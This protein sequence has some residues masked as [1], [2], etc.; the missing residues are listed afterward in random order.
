MSELADNN[1]SF[2][3]KSNNKNFRRKRDE[4]QD[5]E[6]TAEQ[7]EKIENIR[8][9]QKLKRK[10]N[11]GIDA[12]ELLNGVREEKPK[13]VK[14]EKKSGGGLTDAKSIKNDLDLGNTFSVETNRRDEDA[15]MMKF[16][17]QE[18][19]KKKGVEANDGVQIHVHKTAEDAV[20]DVLPQHLIMTKKKESE[21]MLS[22]QMLSGI[23]EVDLGLEEK[24][25][26][27]EDTEDAK[28]TLLRRNRT[29]DRSA[30]TLAPTN[31]A[32]NFHQHNRFNVREDQPSLATVPKKPKIVVPAVTLVEEPVVNVGDE[33]KQRTFRNYAQGPSGYVKHPGKEKPTDDYHFERFRKQFRR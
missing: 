18:L 6:E 9:I 4:E 17:E 2:K 24:I 16:I 28:S 33:P 12:A 7:L 19:A 31:M 3:K 20:F 15:D 23:P 26:N 25:R 30:V 13:L 32:V 5:D 11:K 29:R 14:E 8:E 1:V 22:S 10:V 27:I 21:E